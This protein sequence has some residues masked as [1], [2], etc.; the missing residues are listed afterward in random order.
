M[1]T[2][3][4]FIVFVLIT[5]ILLS[6]DDICDYPVIE[7][8][9]RKNQIFFLH[10]PK[11]DTIYL[12]RFIDESLKLIGKE[13]VEMSRNRNRLIYSKNDCFYKIQPKSSTVFYKK[14]RF[15]KKWIKL[16]PYIK[17]CY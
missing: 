17:M 6:Q 3:T 8:M 12:Y 14:I 16:R 7:K 5:T 1:K 15:K 11:I 10:N 4:I 9:D 13:K 2:Q